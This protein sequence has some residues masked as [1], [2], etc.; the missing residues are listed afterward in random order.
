[1]KNCFL[2]LLIFGLTLGCAKKEETNHFNQTAKIQDGIYMGYFEFQKQNY[3]CEIAFE[4]NQ[5]VEWPSG[6]A[7]F[8]KSYGCL[9]VGSYSVSGYK[10]IFKHG[11]YKMPGFPDSCISEMFL[12]GEYTIYGTM[13]ADSIIFEKGS[14][15][16]KIK[17]HLLKLKLD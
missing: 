15:S 14:G 1:M 16:G 10:L 4:N 8:Q 7:M 17:Y 12:P 13:K 9:T 2:A 6:G 3:W 5:Y 11:S